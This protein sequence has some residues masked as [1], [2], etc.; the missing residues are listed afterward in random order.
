MWGVFPVAEGLPRRVFVMRAG[1][2]GIFLLAL[3]AW[4]C[5]GGDS[6]VEGVINPTGDS[7]GGDVTVEVATDP[8]SS[9]EL[10]GTACMPKTCA[11]LNADCGP[12][13]DGCG[14]LLDCGPAMCPKAGEICGGGGPSK[15]GVA[16]SGCKAKTCV[17][18]DANCGK[19]GD[20]CGNLIDCGT[21]TGTDT[22]GGVTPNKCG[23][24]PKPACTAKTCVEMGYNCGPVADGCGGLVNCGA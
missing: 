8:D 17:E 22:C 4:G 23:T 2:I 3:S 15:C 14:G 9:F 1:R 18:L 10:D 6:E 24:P 19:Q 16:D 20:G 7:S 13:A 11:E 12:V 21:C 5:A